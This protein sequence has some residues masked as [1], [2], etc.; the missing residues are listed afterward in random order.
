MLLV[1]LNVAGPAHGQARYSYSTDGS[2]VTD[3]QTGLVW[4]RCS[5]GQ[6]WSGS[7]CTGSASLHTHEQALALAKA[8]SPWRLP[9][10]KELS[11]LVDVGRIS[12]SIDTTAF[13]GAPSNAFWSSTGY[14]ARYVNKAWSVNLGMGDVIQSDRYFT[15]AVR[16]VR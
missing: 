16:L 8:Q 12:P 4:Q 2:E 14:A 13:P 10:V 11:S 9:N 7:T 15:I 1:G 3:S 6:S 5:Q